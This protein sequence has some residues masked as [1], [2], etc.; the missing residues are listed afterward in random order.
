MEV[1]IGRPSPQTTPRFQRRA[2][3]T[4]AVERAAAASSV[5]ARQHAP[6]ISDGRAASAPSPSR[7]KQRA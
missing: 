4:A 5:I 7:S 1:L 2:R 6:L 3:V